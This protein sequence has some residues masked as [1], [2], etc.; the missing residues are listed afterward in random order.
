[1]TG[2]IAIIGLGQIGTSVGLALKG[3]GGG[4]RLV[5][6]DKDAAATRQAEILGAVDK[7]AGLRDAVRDA[8]IVVLSLPMSE[9]RE[10]LSRIGPLLEEG[11]VVM[12]TAPVKR[13]VAEWARETLPEGRYYV[14]LVPAVN[15]EAIGDT[16]SGPKG[17]RA[18]L[19]RRAVM[20]IDA[21]PGTPPEVEQLAIN[22]AK[23]LGA[24]P[25]LA[26]PTESDGLMTTAHILPQLAAAALLDASL[27]RPGWLEARKLAGP[28]FATVT[29]GLAYFDDPAS[30]VLEALGNP[31]V[32]V[33][34]LDTMIAA[35]KGIRDTVQAGNADQLGQR[36]K[37]AFEGRERWL[38]ERGSAE[39]LSEGGDAAELPQMGEQVLQMLFGGR[40]A[41]R[42]KGQF[43]NAARDRVA[44]DIFGKR[45]K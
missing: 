34:A 27:E 22:L 24:K 17:G 30:I 20:I 10:V 21:Q 23:L 28:P 45:R 6:C 38:D 12:D 29:G 7:I 36:L 40:I 14:G 5:G 11:A 19:F 26:D 1:M 25:L 39:W 43:P 13:Q 15:P 41:D 18:D 37:E 4:A 9:V 44:S 33:H 32:T 35:L 31:T 8:G 16:G 3:R 42:L 2:T